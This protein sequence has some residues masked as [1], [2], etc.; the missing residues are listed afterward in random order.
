MSGYGDFGAMAFENPRRLRTRAH[1]ARK[2]LAAKR[3]ADRARVIARHKGQVKR[4]HVG[5]GESPRH[6]HENR[7]KYA[8]LTISSWQAGNPEEAVKALILA[9]NNGSSPR[10]VRAFGLKRIPQEHHTS[11]V[12][13]INKAAA[14]V[15]NRI[16]RGRK[17]QNLPGTFRKGGRAAPHHRQVMPGVWRR[18]A[19]TSGSTGVAAQVSAQ[20]AGPEFQSTSSIDSSPVSLPQVAT[21]TLAGVYDGVFGGVFDGVFGGVYGEA[22]VEDELLDEVAET[23]DGMKALIVVGAVAGAYYLAKRYGYL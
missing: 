13:F 4:H 19:A 5:R 8:N 9:S 14:Y 1:R 2:A 22:E 16:R 17:A 20:V 3:K 21:A 18:T 23:E 15:P 7:V 10:R 6:R 12:E 11:W